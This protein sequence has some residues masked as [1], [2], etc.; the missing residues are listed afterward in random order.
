MKLIKNIKYLFFC[1]IVF[2]SIN[3][4]FGSLSPNRKDSGQPKIFPSAL[5]YL[6]DYFSHHILIAEKSTHQLHLFKNKGTYPEHIKTFQ[7]ATGKTAGDKILQGDH[8]TPEGIYRFTGF[9]THEDLIKRHGK[10]GEIYGVGAFVMNYPNPIDS[11]LQK[12]GG[13][14][15]LHSTNDETR[16]EKGLDSRGCVVA[17]NNDLKEISTYIE[18]EKTPIVIV[19]N[20]HLLKERTWKTNRN[21]IK[22]SIQNWLNSW[23][24]E[25]Y[26]NYISHYH[27]NK[28]FDRYRGGFKNFKNYKRSVFA[29]PGKPQIEISNLSILRSKNYAV[30]TFK[31]SYISAKIKDIGKKILYLEQDDQYKWKIVN[32]QWGKLLIKKPSETSFRPSMRFFAGHKTAKKNKL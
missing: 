3:K 10:A 5:M 9:L 2:T 16:I 12:T 6:D 28:Y 14:I 7:M 17:A 18:L 23:K 8:K 31:Q 20:M 27:P 26:K 29:N 11:R 22:A 30:A 13:G 25:D 4:T 1:F 32:E 24:A 15:W 21:S 19:Q